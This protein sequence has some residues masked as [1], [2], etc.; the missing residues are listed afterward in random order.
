MTET[1][2]SSVRLR[3]ATQADVDTILGLIRGLAEYIAY[4]KGGCFLAL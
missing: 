3:P 1:T 2:S 4:L